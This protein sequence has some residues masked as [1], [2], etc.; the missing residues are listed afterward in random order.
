M[1]RWISA[2]KNALSSSPH[3]HGLT[4]EYPLGEFIGASLLS[5]GRLFRC[6]VRPMRG[7]DAFSRDFRAGPPVKR[8]RSRF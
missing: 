3:R 8:K 6:Y 5:R 7:R 2:D 4:A 1:S